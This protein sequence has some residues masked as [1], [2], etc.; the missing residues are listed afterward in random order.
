[1]SVV[2]Y[3][4]DEVRGMCERSRPKK[5]RA[6]ISVMGSKN[7][8]AEAIVAKIPSADTFVDCFGG[9]GSVAIAALRSGK[10]RRVIYNE[11]A[12]I[13]YGCFKGAAE[14]KWKGQNIPFVTRR[15]YNESE[16][17]RIRM[18]F[19]FNGMWWS[20]CYNV[21]HEDY[22]RMAHNFVVD[23]NDEICEKIPE[24]KESLEAC[25]KYARNEEVMRTVVGRI[26]TD[27]LGSNG[28]IGDGYK[29]GGSWFKLSHL[30]RNRRLENV[31]AAISKYRSC[32]FE[33]H[34]GS[35][36]QTVSLIGENETAVFYCDPPY[37]DTSGYGRDKE[38]DYPLF[39][40]WFKSLNHPAFLSETN[41]LP[42]FVQVWEE[43]KMGSVAAKGS[44]TS[45]RIE[46][47]YRNMLQVADKRFFG[48][49]DI[50]G[51]LKHVSLDS[52]QLE[53]LGFPY[54]SIDSNNKPLWESEKYPAILEAVIERVK[55]TIEDFNKREE[56]A[57][58]ETTSLQL[59]KMFGSFL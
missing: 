59:T 33:C 54:V 34:Q 23:N 52:S 55:Q 30:E 48:L 27:W 38:F 10:Y 41:V 46:R 16:D 3:S 21:A 31:Q 2:V 29:Q 36:E 7:S 4:E 42:E 24:I 17:P 18:C 28:L 37:K 51:L 32:K 8:V 26:M 50:N 14:G 40:D 44:N 56:R 6:G 9:G 39:L 57:A 19:A 58:Q 49:A 12:D 20:Y 35:Y 1:M 22:A 47:L 13:V 43:V 11:L 45:E 15:E 53:A 25:R 5:G